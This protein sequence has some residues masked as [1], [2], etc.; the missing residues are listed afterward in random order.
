[1]APILPRVWQFSRSLQANVQERSL[2]NH[3]KSGGGT[4]TSRT[5]TVGHRVEVAVGQ[6]EVLR[7]ALGLQPHGDV[8]DPVVEAGEAPQEVDG[9]GAG[10]P[11]HVHRQLVGPRRRLR[12]D[13]FDL[14]QQVA[15]RQDLVLV[16]ADRPRPH[17]GDLLQVL[18]E[19]EPVQSDRLVCSSLTPS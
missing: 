6:H 19:E 4:E 9:E 10:G 18:P 16:A 14:L 13:A 2:A 3:P 7:A 5:W 15:H 17:A 11:L 8:G 12:P 1:M